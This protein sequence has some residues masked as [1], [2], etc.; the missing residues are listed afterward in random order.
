[1]SHADRP[2]LVAP[3]AELPPTEAER[4]ILSDVP[5]VAGGVAAIISS[6]RHALGQAGLVRGTRELLLLNQTR[7]FDCPGCA[8][9]DPDD[10]R[11]LTE[12]CEN[13]AKAVAEEATTKRAT[14]DFFAAHS[15]SELAAWSDYDIGKAGRLT[16]PLRLAPH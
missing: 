10:K 3:P 13:G 6:M 11:E 15:V 14:P 16:H 1:M 4:P 5:E 9:P 8:W 12:F 2:S 7:G